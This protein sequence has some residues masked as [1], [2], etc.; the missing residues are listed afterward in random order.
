MPTPSYRLISH[1]LCPYVQRAAIAMLEKDV[2]FVRENIDLADRP[3]W[4]VALSPLGKVP[5]LV[6]DDESLLFES[7]VIA[8]FVD[9]VSGGGLLAIDPLEK[10]KQRAWIEFASSL[11]A[12]IGRFYNAGS[13]EEFLAAG[14]TL[15]ER[16]R[17]VEATLG[18]GPF[19][20]GDKFSLVDAAFAPVFRYFPVLDQLTGSGFF[21][22]LPKV[23][24]WRD[25]LA[26]RTS[27][28]K[29]VDDDYEVR[30]LDFLAERDS[31]IGRR[32][33]DKVSPQVRM[34]S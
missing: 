29:A 9:D 16:W 21:N 12:G 8:E 4:F 26:A 19:F 23:A 30:L 6:V 17:T 22:D 10:A 31:V 25:E 33:R 15:A 1:H 34:A 5:L 14:D 2:P 20:A 7:S 27:V 32:A 13:R 18:S 11:L 3:G 24:A 28:Q